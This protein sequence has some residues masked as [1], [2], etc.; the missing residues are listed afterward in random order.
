M[1]VRWR[2]PF[3]SGSPRALAQRVQNSAVVWSW[4]FTGL[5]LA[6]GV[7]LLP[8]V[9]R[10]LSDEDLGMYYVLQNLAMIAPMFDFGFSPSVMRFVS[11]AMGG[12]DS[13][14]AHGVTRSAG[15]GPN[16]KL[17]W[18]LFFTTRALYRAIAL[19]MLVVLGLWGTH[20]VHSTM[21]QVSSPAIAL[22]AWAMTLL[23]TVLDTYS[24]WAP[25]FLRGMDEVLLSVRI[26][27]AGMVVRYVVAVALLLAGGGLLSIPAG[28]LLGSIL[29]QIIARRAC[30]RR[31]A[32][33]PSDEKPRIREHLRTI[34]PNSW[35]QGLQSVSSSFLLQ[36]YTQLG[37]S[38]FGLA[39]FGQ[40]G[41]SS[42][43]LNII[44]GV[45]AVWTNVKWQIIGQQRARHDLIGIQRTYWPR[46][47]LQFLTFIVLAAG[48]LLFGQPVL[49][50][51]GHGKHL[52]PLPWLALLSL[53]AFLE[54]QASIWGTL[55]ATGNRIP[56]LWPGVA[57]SVLA[58]VLALILLHTTSI[59]LGAFAAGP[60]IAQS[61][62]N[63]WYWPRYAAREIGTSWARFVFRGP[64]LPKPQAMAVV[65]A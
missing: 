19:L 39:V 12:A 17:L 51:I 44:G 21:N 38:V 14:Q 18:Q 4:V 7:I 8:L 35:R 52:M 28:T 9:L 10:K 16:Y 2:F 45:A 61:L 55:I 33:Q 60:L 64:A 32:R 43:L 25:V 13:L 36:A 30:L 24:S 26:T 59:G 1:I 54:M 37:V 56:Y 62:F 15:T 6:I 22:L 31:L 58:F 49:N 5:K 20:L 63:Y 29:Q 23:A 50:W 57:G 65:E 47:W 34:W 3:V 53:N 11:Y 42:Q 46:M 41:L 48:M 40:Y 27:M